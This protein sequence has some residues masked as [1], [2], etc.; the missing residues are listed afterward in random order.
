M[1]RIIIDPGHGKNDNKGVYPEYKEGTQ[2]WKLAQKE[3]ELLN[4]YECEVICTRPS[5][6]DN[7]SVEARGKMAENADLFI[8]L[9]SNTPGSDSK[10]TPAYEACTGTV[11]FYSVKRPN[12]KEFATKLA[13][14]VGNVMGIYS[15]GAKTKIKKNGDDYYGVIRNAI[16]VDCKHAYIIEH[17]FHT[18][19]H[20]CEFLLNDN[21]LKK[22]AQCEVDLMTSY[23]SIP[24]TPIEDDEIQHGDLV[25]I[26]EGA[27]YTNGKMVPSR[28]LKYNWFVDQVKNDAALIGK[29]EDGEHSLSSWIEVKYLEK[30]P[31][32]S[33]EQT[34]P[35]VSINTNSLLVAL[36]SIGVNSSFKV[37][38]LIAK[39][40]GIKFYIGTSSQNKKLLD[41]LKEGECLKA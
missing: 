34:Y 18:N 23:Y 11:S 14:D 40:N 2:M 27:T 39:A 20:D 41:L 5:I 25:K 29:S 17:G 38:K 1:F 24:L 21:N 22:I 28:Y 3:I 37:R 7:P 33:T 16:E 15:R 12:D 9:H 31:S 10:G 6:D 32:E 13:K 19:R 36:T 26:V 8:S 35:K 30:V 4:K